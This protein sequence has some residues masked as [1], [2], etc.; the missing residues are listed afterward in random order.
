MISNSSFD[1]HDA[2]LPLKER[3]PFDL[4]AAF[5]QQPVLETPRIKLRP[6]LDSDANDLFKVY[7]DGLI[8]E[9]N[10][11]T[12]LDS[13]AKVAD[14]IAAFQQQFIAHKRIRWGLELKETGCIVGDCAFVTFDPR[15]HLGEIGF[16]LAHE[17]W[18]KG[19]MREAVLAM[20][21]YGFEEIGLNRIVGLV[22]TENRR[23]LSLLQKLGFETEG[24]LR[25]GGW[26]RDRYRD[27]ELSALLRDDFARQLH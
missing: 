5:A 1:Y 8:G 6:L 25:Q 3:P 21:R 7:G 12:T 27:M 26:F 24:Y 2:S 22:A 11:W 17:F 19:L 4:E 16:N 23:S 14:K 13:F 18:G 20:I 15:G 9:H 10:G